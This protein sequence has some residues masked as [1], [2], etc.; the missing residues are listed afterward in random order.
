MNLLL[1][2]KSSRG[3]RVHDGEGD[4]DEENTSTAE[5]T[6]DKQLLDDPQ[7]QESSLEPMVP[8]KKNTILLAIY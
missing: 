3:R 4:G 5:Q 6:S 2:S 7:T 1:Q 8:K